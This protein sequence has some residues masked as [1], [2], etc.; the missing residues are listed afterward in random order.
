M[1]DFQKV[2]AALNTMQVDGGKPPSHRGG[3]SGGAPLAASEDLVDQQGYAVPR[4]SLAGLSGS[5]AT[6]S[7]YSNPME[8]AK[9]SKQQQRTKL[10]ERREQLAMQQ[11][12]LGYVH[13]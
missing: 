9:A 7:E 10:R 3:V 5:G 2:Q 4:D 12:N 8:E 13:P 1:N 11:G 6:G